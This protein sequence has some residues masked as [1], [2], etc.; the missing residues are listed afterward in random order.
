LEVIFDKVEL[1]HASNEVVGMHIQLNETVF[2]LRAQ[3]DGIFVTLDTIGNNSAN[4]V[5]CIVAHSAT[6]VLLSTREVGI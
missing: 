4:K 3:E 1:E 5:I 6:Q 2:I